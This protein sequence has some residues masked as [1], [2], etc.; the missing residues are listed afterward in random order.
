M[1]TY[2]LVVPREYGYVVLV[3]VGSTLVNAWLS[4]RVGRARRKYDVKYPAMY[5]DTNIV[6][7]CIQRS[8]QNFLEGYPQFLMTLF[9]A[10]FEF[11]LGDMN[12]TPLAELWAVF[13]APAAVVP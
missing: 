8:H 6:F 7:N 2:S 10:G 13:S 4:F 11:P 3:G 5:S 9:L 1:T 12:S